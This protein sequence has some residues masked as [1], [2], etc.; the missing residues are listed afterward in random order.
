MARTWA[1]QE[2]Y[3]FTPDTDFE[4]TNETAWG[5]V[6]RLGGT[7]RLSGIAWYRGSTGTPGP[8]S[9]SIW[10]NVSGVRLWRT[11]SPPDDGAVGWQQVDLTDTP[12][13]FAIINSQP[14]VSAYGGSGVHRTYGSQGSAFVG[15]VPVNVSL[16]QGFRNNSIGDQRPTTVHTGT[17][18]GLDARF[19]II[20]LANQNVISPNVEAELARWLREDGDHYDESAIKTILGQAA[21]ANETV[22]STEYGNATIHQDTQDLLTRWSADLATKLNTAADTVGS[23][24]TTEANW[25]RQLV[26]DSAGTV[27]SLVEKIGEITD[28]TVFELLAELIRWANGVNQPPQLA[29]TSDWQ[30]VDE[31]DFTDNLLWP[32]EAD[33]YRV[34][35]S[36]FD[37]AGTS[38]PVGTETRHAHLGK[39]CPFNV[40]FSSEWHYFNTASADLYV[41][42]RM[43]GLG[44]ILNRPG[45]G[46]VQAWRRTEAP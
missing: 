4:E 2:A 41:G 40:Q 37:P 43:P 22:Q 6:Y 35:L 42:D 32:V 18:Q 29:D 10:D 7:A 23:W 17:I 9:L 12:F 1:L 14:M 13:D 33:V 3:E 39:W 27:A 15:E 19:E 16:Q 36:S 44:L 25:Y 11:D 46:H 21:G 38:E 28:L 34:T 45:A 8:S 30:L 24:L 31:T 5:Q 26:H 20:P